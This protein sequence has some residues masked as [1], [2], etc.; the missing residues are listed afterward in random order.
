MPKKLDLTGQKFNRLLVLEPASNKGKRTQWKCA[1]DCGNICIASTEG[2][3][4]GTTKSCGC[5]KKEKT[6]ERN[7]ARIENLIGCRFGRLT[8][9]KQAE[10]RR[11][12]SC[13][14]CQCD[15]G[16]IK[17]VCSVELKKGDTLSCGCLRSSFGE[18]A[19]KRILDE[20]NISYNKEYE[21]PELVSENQVPLRFD[22][23]IFDSNGYISR[24]I[25]YD[26]EQHYLEKTNNFWKNDSLEKRQ[27][28]DKQKNEYCL[29]HNYSLVRIPYWEKNNI[30]LELILG[31][32]YLVSN[33]T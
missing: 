17:E 23:V 32:K 9:I 7:K 11:G 12:H 27:K 1:C 30:S 33:E 25:E 19:I 31:D 2:L 21:F 18:T 29:K 24:I 8:V 6:I 4:N 3:R 16:N 14:I 10:S 28:R 20:N 26:G 5:L 22:F 13:W 15:C